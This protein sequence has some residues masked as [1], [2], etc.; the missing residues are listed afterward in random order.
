MSARF[1]IIAAVIGWLAL[2][3]QYGLVIAGNIGPSPL[4]RT[5]NFF[6]YFTVLCNILAALALSA[7]W[8]MPR[9]AFGRFLMRPPVRA[10]IASYIIVVLVTYD[11]ILSDLL[12]LQG[13]AYVVDIALHYVMPVLFVLDWLLFA[14]KGAL[15]F[16]DI[17]AWLIFPVAYVAW[18]FV[19]GAL[20]GFYPYPFVDVAALG[21]ARTGVNV[22]GLFVVFLVLAVVIT[23]LD[24]QWAKVT[25]RRSP[26]GVNPPREKSMRG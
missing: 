6:S 15:R 11:L 1:R 22:V 19:H 13:L 17:P 12:E 2:I 5:I 26:A 3:L 18:T 14:P 21:Y 24:H 7:P 20:S 9:T 16:R 10:A 23:A 8:L 25:R 4:G